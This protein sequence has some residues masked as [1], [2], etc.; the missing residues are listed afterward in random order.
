MPYVDE[1]QPKTPS[2]MPPIL[3]ALLAVVMAGVGAASWL[4]C[5]KWFNMSY[6]G[7]LVAGLLI[8]LAIRFTL[9]KPIPQFRVAAIILTV[10]ASIAG[11]IWVF[12]AFYT[13]F[14]FGGSITN[15]FRDIQALLFTGAG[16]YIA[17]ALASPRFKP[18]PTQ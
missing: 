13:N 9:N 18:K 15:Y 3:P 6:P 4:G 8:G 14:T 1:S 5:F 17:F 10:L 2:N 11:Y 12:A 16:S 7:A